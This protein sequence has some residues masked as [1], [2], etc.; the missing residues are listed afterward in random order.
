MQLGDVVNGDAA[1]Y[2]RP[3]DGVRIL[4]AE[5][6]QALP[7][8]TQLLARLGADVVKV[9]HPG[10]GESG[11]GSF[12]HMVDPDGR[13]VGATFLRNNLNKRS[14]AIDLKRPEGRELFLSLV[15][16]FDVVCENFK[17]GT[18]DRLGL[19]YDVIA[20]R[21]PAAVYL[22]LSG[23]GNTVETPYRNWPAYASIVEAMSGIYEYKREPGRGPRAN[24]VGALGDISSA[25]FGTIGVLAAL[26][27]RDRTG[28]G[29]QIDVAMLDAL[30]AMTDIVANLWSMGIHGQIEDEIKAI[31]DSFAAGDGWFVLQCV[32]PQHFTALAQVIGRPEWND[33]PRFATSAGWIDNIGEVRAA[34]E[35]WAAPMTKFEAAAAL[36]AAG[37]AAGPCLTPPEVIADPHVAARHMLVETPRTDDPD[38]EHGPILVPGNPVKMSKVAEGPETRV[39][40]LGEHTAEVLAAE[41]G[42]GDDDLAKL[43][44]EGVIG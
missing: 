17:A 38:G 26:R 16:R 30:V 41:L 35:A 12:P 37:L 29:Q 27:H 28:E 11:R 19:G 40:W 18:M 42:L 32:R 44:A 43:R 36:S 10:A 31:V 39:P 1:P 14:V 25:L 9:E 3:L 33:D 13:T 6:M 23:F 4:A 21:H 24:P 7:Y 2:G 5:Q 34:I 20:E 8:A 15:P 22:S